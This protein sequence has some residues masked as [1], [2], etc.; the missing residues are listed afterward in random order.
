M[1]YDALDE[2]TSLSA[3]ATPTSTVRETTYVY[4]GAHRI[5]EVHDPLGGTTTMT[6]DDDSHL[7]GRTLPNGIHSTWTYNARGWVMSVVHE[8]ADDTV[9][10]SS[11]YLRSP[12][13]EPTRITRE[14]GTY[15]LLDYDSA[16]RIQQEAYRAADGSVIENIEYAYDR[17]G[18]RT[19]RRVGA[20]EA[21][22][23]VET[24]A[25][26]AGDELRT[27]SVEGAPIAT[28]DYDSAGRT[29][30]IARGARSQSLAYDADNHLTSVVEGASE[31]RWQFDAEGR[32]VARE[33]L[34]AGIT[35]QAHRFV[36]GPTHTAS[37][38]SAHLVTTTTGAEELGY[39]FAPI[40]GGQEHPLFRYDPVTSEVVYYLQD[41]MGSV[42]GLADGTAANTSTLQY[43][44]FGNERASTGVL[45]SL[46]VESR[47]DYRFHGMWR[48]ASTDLY[49]VRARTYDARTGRFLSRDPV[50]GQRARPETFEGSRA[51]VGNPYVM[52][53]PAGTMT[54]REVG[55]AIVS[56]AIL[57][58]NAYGALRGAWAVLRSV[59][60]GRVTSEDG[61]E[62]GVGVISALAIFGPLLSGSGLVAAGA[63]GERSLA[64]ALGSLARARRVNDALLGRIPLSELTWFERVLGERYFRLMST[65][66][67]GRH[68]SAAQAFNIA[69]AEFLEGVRD[70][71]PGKLLD[72]M[73]ETNLR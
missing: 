56:N 6:Y 50:E 25:Y 68:A 45:A 72:F 35:T 21:S 66:V 12:T 15:V 58:M 2:L 3:R 39:V 63:T 16:L 32:R 70:T 8:R 30:H 40:P 55:S 69:R 54:L 34:S 51:F 36:V 67:G 57:A 59:R 64:G 20:T 65:Q 11:T 46:P 27:V 4:D 48:D 52:R 42:I 18:N 23:V 13:G 33:D 31:T 62:I 43:D 9:I 44:G 10:A 37:L 47:G 5:T 1:G 14:D 29:T 73:R 17:D 41:A 7:T 22:M 28:Y 19:T 60:D 24:Y 49:Y 38:E 53:D 71:P 61:I 26:D